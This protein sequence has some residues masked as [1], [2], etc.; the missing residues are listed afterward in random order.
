MRRERDH[1]EHEQESRDPPGAPPVTSTR[2]DGEEQRGERDREHRDHPHGPQRGGLEEREGGRVDVGDERR[3]AVD[4]GVLVEL[5]AVVDD[6]GLGGEEG[7][8]G[9]EDRHE[10]RRGRSAKVSASSTRNIRP[11]SRR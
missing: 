2:F 8:V 11:R 9:V 6:V 4:R 10:E 5:A 7:L 3:L 1:R